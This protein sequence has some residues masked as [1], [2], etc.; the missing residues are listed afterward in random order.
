MSQIA[1]SARIGSNST[2]GAYSVVGD[3]VVVGDDC[4]IGHHVVIH[5][6]SVI[7]D[8]VRIDDHTVIGKMPMRAVNS[9]TSSAVD[10]SPCTIGEQCLIGTG[11]VIYAGAV[12]G[13]EVLVADQASV[14]EDV[15][16]GERTIVGRGA[17]VENHCLIGQCCKLETNVY[18]TAYSRL[19]D[20]VFVAPGVLTSNDNF[21]GRTEER[22]KH[23]KGVTIRRG[24][25]LGVGAVILP[26]REIG[27]DSVVAGGAVVTKDTE[28]SQIVAGTPARFFRQ[29]PEEQLL[30]RQ[31]WFD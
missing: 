13:K 9:A 14:R 8:G 23:F 2:L 18:I 6:G 31:N 21:I 20:Y 17:S 7:G 15:V 28:S 12:I 25:R 30:D 3:N 29:V 27:S 1:Q 10:L 22:F 11:V 26:G 16:I 4:T 19:E 24:G 5:D